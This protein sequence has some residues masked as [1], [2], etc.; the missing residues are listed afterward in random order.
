MPLSVVSTPVS[1]AGEETSRSRY[2]LTVSCVATPFIGWL[3]PPPT[4]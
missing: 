1:G 3:L 4:S 2:T